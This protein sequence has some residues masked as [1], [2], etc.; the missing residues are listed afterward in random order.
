MAN[1]WSVEKR[2]LAERS[3]VRS[4][5]PARLVGA[6]LVVFTIVLVAD[7]IFADRALFDEWPPERS[8]PYLVRSF[9]LA[10]GSALAVSGARLMSTMRLPVADTPRLG[11]SEIASGLLS[12][13]IAL[14]SAL[15][16]LIDPGSLTDLV[17]ED[18]LVEWASA[19]LS[20]AAGG[21][22]LATAHRYWRSRGDRA[23]S[24]R[25]VAAFVVLGGIFLLLGLEEVSWFQ[26]VLDVESPDAFVNRNSQ[27]ELNLH[28]FATVATG[29][30]LYAGGFVFGVALPLLLADRTLPPRLGWLQPLV[31]RQAVLA[32]SVV[33]T[34]VVFSMWNVVLIQI[35]FWMSLTATLVARPTGLAR[36]PG[37]LLAAAMIAVV[38]IYLGA[39]DSMIR[40]WDDTEVREVIIPFGL[41][42]YALGVLA[43]APSNRRRRLSL[44]AA[45]DG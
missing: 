5:T 29:N 25:T 18:G 10:L 1:D 36:V 7:R 15:L 9:G 13:S 22:V 39:G 24:V 42:V 27:K 17:Q 40:D 21:L 4:R 3:P 30:A 38:S 20:F 28:N 14:G 23:A 6:G 45:A 37:L 32:S 8:A 41:V 12:I 19:V 34:A 11:P 2:R 33:A 16:L 35:T 43:A 44:V 26:R 31:P